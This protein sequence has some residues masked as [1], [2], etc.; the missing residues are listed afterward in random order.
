MTIDDKNEYGEIIRTKIENGR[1]K[2]HH[3]DCSDDFITLD[4]LFKN[5]M[6]NPSELKIIYNNVKLITHKNIS[7][8]MKNAIL[9]K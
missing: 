1:I 2:I 7:N 9:L 8:S 3:T 5:Y 6:L 4:E